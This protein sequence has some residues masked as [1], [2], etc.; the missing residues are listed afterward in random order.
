LPGPLAKSGLDVPE[1]SVPVHRGGT[2]GRLTKVDPLV[3]TQCG[4]SFDMAVVKE[5]APGNDMVIEV[6]KPNDELFDPGAE[7]VPLPASIRHREI[8]PI[9]GAGDLIEVGRSVGVE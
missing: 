7:I 2:R 6:R 3:I 8:R 5:P 1:S 9:D 4:Q